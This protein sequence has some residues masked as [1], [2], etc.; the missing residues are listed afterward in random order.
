MHLIGCPISAKIGHQMCASREG[1]V[2]ETNRK[3]LHRD[4]MCAP[5]KS[6]GSR[7]GFYRGRVNSL[8]RLALHSTFSSRERGM[9][10]AAWGR[11]LPFPMF[12]DAEDDDDESSSS[13]SA[14]LNH[15]DRH[16][17]HSS[18]GSG[19]VASSWSTVV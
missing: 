10:T 13:S 15:R 3:A 2:W 18:D 19:S 9:R 7:E 5:A 12:N 1:K 6:W 8:T 16:A 4:K 11:G 14:S 17:S